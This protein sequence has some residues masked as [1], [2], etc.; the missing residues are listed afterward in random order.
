MD[1][2]RSL[3]DVIEGDLD[4]VDVCGLLE[5]G[6]EQLDQGLVV[7]VVA[8]HLQDLLVADEALMI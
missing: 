7:D 6:S 5:G 1:L 8:D 2:V 3:G 4:L